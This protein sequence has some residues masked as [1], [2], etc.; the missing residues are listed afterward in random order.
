MFVIYFFFVK[1]KRIIFEIEVY[2]CVIWLSIFLIFNVENN[3]NDMIMNG[4]YYN[5]LGR[6]CFYLIDLIINWNCVLI[7]WKWYEVMNIVNIILF[8][9]KFY[10]LNWKLIL[11]VFF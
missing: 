9:N 6:K 10:I 8:L 1:N 4:Y 7:L 2:V 11:Y 5:K 3:D